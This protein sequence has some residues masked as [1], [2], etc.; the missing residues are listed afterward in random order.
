MIL[1][2]YSFGFLGLRGALDVRGFLIVGSASSLY[3]EAGSIGGSVF[4]TVFTDVFTD[5]AALGVLA[6][7]LGVFVFVV[8]GATGAKVMTL[9]TGLR[10]AS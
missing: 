1:D 8:G 4:F 9:V 10:R 5:L 3:S 6:F 2:A 7:A